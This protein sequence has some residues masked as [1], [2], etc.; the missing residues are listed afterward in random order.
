L[1]VTQLML[2]K[3]ELIHFCVVDDL[4]VHKFIVKFSFYCTEYE[5]L[6]ET[7][8]SVHRYTLL[9]RSPDLALGFDVPDIY[10]NALVMPHTAWNCLNVVYQQSICNGSTS[11]LYCICTLALA[12]S[13]MLALRCDYILYRL[14]RPP[15]H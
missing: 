14:H 9:V 1:H 3:I 10:N 8:F 13:G 7:M 4:P 5:R 15:I 2:L 11:Y 6:T 12:A